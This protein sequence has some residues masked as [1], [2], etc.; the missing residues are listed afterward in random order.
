MT[1]RPLLF[2]LLLLGAVGQAAP[3]GASPPAPARPAA[4]DLA[5]R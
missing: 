3:A 2:C 5:R 4:G 1:V